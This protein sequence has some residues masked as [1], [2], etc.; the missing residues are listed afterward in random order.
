ML[1]RPFRAF[2]ILLGVLFNLLPAFA[3]DFYAGKTVTLISPF[4]A[5]GEPIRTF[6]YFKGSSEDTFPAL[7]Q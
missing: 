3:E 1:Q 7:R 5:G 6:A 2:V 4:G